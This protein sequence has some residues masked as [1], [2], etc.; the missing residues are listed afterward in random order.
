M[1]KNVF[2]ISLCLLAATACNT[3]KESKK[4]SNTPALVT[5]LPIPAGWTTEHFEIPISFAPSILYK[6]REDIRFTPG[7]GKYGSNDYWS[8]AFL[9]TLE[10]SPV[11]TAKTI[12]QHL[13]FYYTG[14]IGTNF[15][16]KKNPHDTIT[17]TV[18]SI[19]KAAT[20]KNDWET[21]S[22]TV[23]MFDYMAHQPITLNCMIH[24]KVCEKQGKT[25]LFHQISPKPFTD[26][27]W[28][29]LNALWDGFACAPN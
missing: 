27:V 29:G 8:Y 3:K 12:E 26:S 9:W 28:T 20:Q 13:D 21:F 14:L 6:G 2:L 17:P 1:R 22:G 5:A 25:L 7:W 15:D 11:I 16:R 10:D 24:L 18:V 19:A 4:E 23:Q